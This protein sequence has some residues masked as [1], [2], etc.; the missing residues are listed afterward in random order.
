MEIYLFLQ[1]KCLFDH[2]QDRLFEGIIKFLL[3][4]LVDE[5]DLSK[6]CM[7]MKLLKLGIPILLGPSFSSEFYFFFYFS[8]CLLNQ[9]FGTIIC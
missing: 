1:G 8:F 3:F 9:P 6:H 4:A 5:L 2:A 7:Q